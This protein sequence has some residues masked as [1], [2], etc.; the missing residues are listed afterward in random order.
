MFDSIAGK[1]T[2]IMRT[3][4]GKGKISEKNVRDAVEEIK[5]QVPCCKVSF[6]MLGPSGSGGALMRLKNVELTGHFLVA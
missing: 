3:L 2:G 4:S 1:F 6:T 5:D